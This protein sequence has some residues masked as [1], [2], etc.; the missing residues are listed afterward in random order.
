MTG[1]QSN[2]FFLSIPLT[3][4]VFS[5]YNIHEEENVI[6]MEQYLI[7]SKIF[8]KEIGLNNTGLKIRYH[9]KKNLLDISYDTGFK[10]GNN[11]NQCEK[12]II[13]RE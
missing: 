12:G 7:K 13:N 5:P 11:E 2:N 1:L 10:E 9:K 8:L 6:I 3:I 4:E